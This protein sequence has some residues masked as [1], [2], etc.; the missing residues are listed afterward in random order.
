MLHLALPATS[1]GCTSNTSNNSF[2]DPD[3]TAGTANVGDGDG[4]VDFNRPLASSVHITFCPLLS[5]VPGPFLAMISAVVCFIASA[6]ASTTVTVP[7][8]GPLF[9][10]VSAL[11][12][13]SNVLYVCGQGQG[14]WVRG[15][16]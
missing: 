3:C 14:V 2:S 9:A 4:V 13:M 12:V 15:R 1:A 7:L 6:K 10:R 16:T 5:L 11:C 8:F